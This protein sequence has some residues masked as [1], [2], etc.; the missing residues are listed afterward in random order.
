ML[1]GDQWDLALLAPIATPS[2]NVVLI[3][4]DSARNPA[5]LGVVVTAPSAGTLQVN[6]ALVATQGVVDSLGLTSGYT[7]PSVANAF[8]YALDGERG[9]LFV[10]TRNPASGVFGLTT[11]DVMRALAGSQPSGG[12][13]SVTW[14]G[15][16]LGTLL[17][18][19]YSNAN[20]QLYVLDRSDSG[21]NSSLRLFSLTTAGVATQLWAT[22]PIASTGFPGNAFLSGSR[23]NA[24]AVSL[25]EPGTQKAEIMSV[26]RAGNPLVSIE[27]N[28][29]ISARATA[30]VGGGLWT[31]AQTANRDTTL[32]PIRYPAPIA[33]ICGAS[34]L[35]AVAGVSGPLA[36]AVAS[37]NPI[38]NGGFE[39]GN[40]FYWTPSGA[41]VA[42][43]STS[44][45]GGAYAALLGAATPTN[46]DSTIKQTFTVPAGGGTLKFWYSTTC[47][48]TVTYD[49]FTAQLQN[50]SG[51][52][53]ATLV[54]P[55]CV[56]S[57][58]WTQVTFNLAAYANQ[59]VV[60]VAT[61]HDDN[62]VGDPTYTLV[63]DVSVQ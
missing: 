40:F 57:S 50:T 41:S 17:G 12:G 26:D 10:I 60:V 49:W 28:D 2:N 43:S 47:P 24:L 34:W 25:W 23:G 62:Y 39:T 16:N 13:T 61:N 15:P 7:T 33:N 63:D 46:G 22:V 48:D 6:G 35:R 37:C 3:D 19:Q 31:V 45:H 20:N 54:A 36:T 18:V 38:T 56:A 14:S 55:T 42:I 21:G 9:L 5:L 44:P 51:T 29:V 4:N 58:G 59:T 1:R 30:D 27:T 11:L 8:G 52:T 32:T 53:L